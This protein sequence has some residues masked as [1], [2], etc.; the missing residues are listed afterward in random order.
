MKIYELSNKVLESSN[1]VNLFLDDELIKEL[2]KRAKKNMFSITE[3]VEDIL[4][5]SVV[6]QKNKKSSSAYDEK[7]DDTLVALF[8]RKNTGP[9][10]KRT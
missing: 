4:R 10:G 6:T 7:L 5:R 3:Q 8:S 9:K 2:D 1:Q